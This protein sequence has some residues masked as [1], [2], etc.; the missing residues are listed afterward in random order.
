[1]ALLLALLVVLAII[2]GV[3]E[4]ARPAP[5]L[6]VQ[7]ALPEHFA[8]SGSAPSLPWPSSGTA[9]MAVGGVGMVGSSGGDA[10]LPLASVTKMMTA[11]IVLR[12]HPLTASQQG[13]LLTVTPAD[14]TDYQSKLADGESVVAVQAGETLSERQAL[15]GLLLPSGNNIA[16]L[17]AEWDAGSTSAFVAKMNTTAAG[18]GLS[19]THYADPSGIDPASVGTATEQVTLA[20]EDMGSPAFAS[21]VAEPQATLPVAG[22]VYNVNGLVG[23]DGVVGVKTGSTP[24]TG[25]DLVFAADR[26]VAGHPI[27]LYGAV[28]GQKG[29]SPMAATFSETESLLDAMTADLRPVTVVAKGAEGARIQAAWG[30]DVP[31][32][33]KTAV[34]FVGWTGM[35]VRTQLTSRRLGNQVMDG[36]E[37]GSLRVTTGSQSAE[38]GLVASHLSPAPSMLWR[39]RHV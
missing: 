13:P 8:V 2:Y 39:L 23:H 5:S 11:L 19:H 26:T 10:P 6:T 3:V 28:F 25:S 34:S 7:S 22:V 18:L 38:V 30:A 16:D 33:A 32:V 20:E 9:A 1:M 21:I 14:V 36:Q 27:V 35:Q 29:A 24:E 4:L 37:V 15:E 31:A 12:D 17:L